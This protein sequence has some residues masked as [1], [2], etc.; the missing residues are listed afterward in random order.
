MV[1]VLQRWTPAIITGRRRYNKNNTGSLKP[2]RPDGRKTIEKGH[3]KTKKAGMP[4]KKKVSTI[5]SIGGFT[6]RLQS[7]G[8]EKKLGTSGRKQTVRATTLPGKAVKSRGSPRWTKGKI[9]LAKATV[10]QG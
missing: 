7:G 2:T 5:G 9:V 6:E 3:K 8:K 4:G 10:R 1:G